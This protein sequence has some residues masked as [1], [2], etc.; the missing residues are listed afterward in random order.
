MN[1][2]KIKTIA[3]EKLFGMYD[4]QLTVSPGAEDNVFIIYGDN[5]TGK[6]T[7]L[8]LT[9][10]LLAPEMGFS[11]KSYL[12]NVAFKSFFVEFN[13][14]V[15]VSAK[16][17]EENE[18]YIGDYTLFYQ[19]NE[20]LECTIPCVWN[21]ERH[22]YIVN[23]SAFSLLSRKNYRMISAELNSINVFYISDNRNEEQQE[24]TDI[25]NRRVLSSDPVEREMEQL[26]DWVIS[27]AL[28][29]NKKG[30]EGTTAVY[31]KILSK[32]GTRRT[33]SDIALSIEDIVREINTLEKR[34]TP[35]AEIG[36]IPMT[37]YTDI[38]L[39]LS[40]VHKTKLV[41]TANILEPYLE[42][43][44]NRLDALDH[45]FETISYLCR[46]LNEYLY[47]KRV[48]YSV[49]DGFKFYQNNSDSTL[50]VNEKDVVS[51]KKLSSGERQLLRL[52]SMVIRKS[53]VCPI[54]IIDEPEIS[55]NIK[56]QRRLLTTLNY[57][58]RNSDAQFLIATH[59]F[60]ILSSHIDNTVRV[61]DP[62]VCQAND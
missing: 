5:G 38:K 44:K 48:I 29:A 34:A 57:F 42:T 47:K 28:E 2:R 37:N 4:Y 15:R 23:Y 27:Q 14:G 60:E 56:W 9:Y 24:V 18:D 7:L 26:Q 58:V 20:R 32:L 8:R 13:D 19:R 61:G 40:K 21:D 51:V 45:L 1:T 35:Y 3:V 59:S 11:H 49:D 50:N 53:N 43:Q 6:S 22:K 30:E 54:I 62:D 16:R 12:A 55:L 17:D 36:F 41:A 39:R 33:K 46:S 10:H 52:F 31:V 25:R